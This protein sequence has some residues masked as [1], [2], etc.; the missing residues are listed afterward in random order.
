MI[1]EHVTQ[2]RRAQRS[3]D[4][5]TMR[6]EAMREQRDHAIRACVAEGR[7]HAQ[8]FRALDG[9]VTRG[10]IGQIVGGYAW[11]AGQ[12]GPPTQADEN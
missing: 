9:A 1:P 8:V 6:L 7:T 3:L 5:A 10:R 4:R 2:L 11:H 12:Y